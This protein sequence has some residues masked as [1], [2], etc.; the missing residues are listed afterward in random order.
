MATN[1]E[2]LSFKAWVIKDTDN[3]RSEPKE[4]TVIRLTDAL[5][6]ITNERQKIFAALDSFIEPM[7]I[8][9]ED[10]SSIEMPTMNLLKYLEFQRDFKKEYVVD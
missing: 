8:H 3:H 7:Q 4:I 6:A 9:D 10:G 2:I 1:K 5:N